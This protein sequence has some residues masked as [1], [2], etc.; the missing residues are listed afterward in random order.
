[1]RV[2]VKKTKAFSKEKAYAAFIITLALAFF[3]LYYVWTHTAGFGRTIEGRTDFACVQ[4]EKENPGQPCPQIIAIQTEKISCCCVNVKS[5]EYNDPTSFS[6]GKMG[7]FVDAGDNH[8]ESCRKACEARST[9]NTDFRLLN[10]GYC[11]Y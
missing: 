1:M 9:A 4:W 3:A 8:E 11:K 5:G 2:K 6:Q 10:V 7:I